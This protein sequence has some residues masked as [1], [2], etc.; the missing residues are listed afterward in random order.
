VWL[1]TGTRNDLFI[2]SPR[3]YK[4]KGNWLP[5]LS[6]CTRL[7]TGVVREDKTGRSGDGQLNSRRGFKRRM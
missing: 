3:A 2:C 6:S 7:G 1:L 5:G 4:T